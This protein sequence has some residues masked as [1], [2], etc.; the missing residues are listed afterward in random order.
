MLVVAAANHWRLIKGDVTSAFLQ[1]REL[2]KP[3]YVMP[4]THLQAAFGVKPGVPLQVVKPGYGIGEAPRQWWQTVEADF[5]RLGLQTCPIEPCLWFQRC[6]R[7]Q[8]LIGL[9]MGHVD[10]FIFAGDMNHPIWQ[11]TVSKIQRLYAW[12]TWESMYDGRDQL[13]QCGV[14]IV[15][16]EDGFLLHQKAYT[17]KLSHYSPTGGR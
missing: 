6:P 12:G 5:L 10:D 15:S 17:S 16:D 14:T 1:A 9:I 8:E 2:T 11:S 4:D 7:S 3:L 13:E